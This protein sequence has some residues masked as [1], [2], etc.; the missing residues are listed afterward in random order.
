LP[1]TTLRVSVSVPLL[2]MP[3][4][5]LPLL[6]LIVLSTKVSVPP[7]LMAPPL[8]TYQSPLPLKVLAVTVTLPEPENTP[9]PYSPPMLPSI[10]QPVSVTAPPPGDPM[11][12]PLFAVLPLTRLSIIVRSAASMAM[13]P[14]PPGLSPLRIARPFSTSAPPA[15][16]VSW[17]MAN[18][19]VAPDGRAIVTPSG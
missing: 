6:P 3:A 19:L 7:A 1:A 2:R 5:R 16:A 4:P 13:P 10:V 8:V 12:L 11:P 14:P 9:P 17:M 18:F 15:A